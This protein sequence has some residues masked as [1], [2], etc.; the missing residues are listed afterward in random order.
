VP[1]CEPDDQFAMFTRLRARRHNQAAIRSAREIGY[2][3]L[4]FSGVAHAARAK[5]HPQLR[6]SGLNGVQLSGLKRDVTDPLEHLVV[7]LLVGCP[8]FPHQKVYPDDGLCRDYIEV[9]IA[10]IA[11]RP[12]PHPFLPVPPQAPDEVSCR[13]HDD[14]GQDDRSLIYA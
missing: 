4:D 10:Q 11:P 5:L 6:G 1:G 3:V 12:F 9:G 13:C 7:L 14:Q 8:E 2:A